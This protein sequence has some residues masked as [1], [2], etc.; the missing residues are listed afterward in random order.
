MTCVMI[1]KKYVRYA[2]ESQSIKGV[3][4]HYSKKV[5]EI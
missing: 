1:Y 2:K 4:L 3:N 5:K